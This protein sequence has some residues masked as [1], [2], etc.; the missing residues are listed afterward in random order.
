MR[1]VVASVRF[2][3]L[4]DGETERWYLGIRNGDL[5]VSLVDSPRPAD[6]VMTARRAVFDTIAAGGSPMSAMLRGEVTLDGE[7][8][9]WIVC[10][11]LLP[12][13]LRLKGILA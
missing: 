7:P 8:E 12:E 4:R 10:R 9:V 2:D 13:P 5:S 6:C 11:R 3:L 1:N